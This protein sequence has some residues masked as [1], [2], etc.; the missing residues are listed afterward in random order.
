MRLAVLLLF[1]AGLTVAAAGDDPMPRT[2]G[3]T[4]GRAWKNF[5]SWVK[6][7]YVTGFADG[8]KLGSKSADAAK[9]NGKSYYGNSDFAEIIKALD[10]FYE[11]PA[12][13]QVPIMA[14]MV[15]FQDKVNGKSPSVLAEELA[16]FRKVAASQQ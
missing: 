5:N 15:Y 16:N 1:L 8:I 13:S 2:G 6:L 3:Y 11:D 4:N 10:T 7:G 12:N 9:E 14:A